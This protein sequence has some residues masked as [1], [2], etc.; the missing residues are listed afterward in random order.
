MLRQ[1]NPDTMVRRARAFRLLADGAGAEEVARDV[2]V[3]TSTLR[4]WVAEE[5]R[6]A[7]SLD[8]RHLAPATFTSTN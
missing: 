6:A 1:L 8:F 3:S 5:Q 7:A 4:R 2:G